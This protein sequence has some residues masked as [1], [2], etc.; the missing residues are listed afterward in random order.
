MDVID[1]AGADAP[2]AFTDETPAR[3]GAREA[4]YQPPAE[5]ERQLAKDHRIH[6]TTSR[7]SL[8]RLAASTAV[9]NSTAQGRAV[10]QRH[11]QKPNA[12]KRSFGA[13]TYVQEQLDEALEWLSDHKSELP[14]ENLD[15]L[16]YQYFE[17]KDYRI[18]PETGMY[19]DDD[20]E[21]MLE[22]AWEDHMIF[23]CVGKQDCYKPLH[24]FAY[25]KDANEYR[26]FGIDLR[27]YAYFM[28]MRGEAYRKHAESRDN[29]LRRDALGA[30]EGVIQARRLYDEGIRINV[31]ELPP[32]ETLK[33]WF[34]FDGNDLRWAKDRSPR[35]RKD[36]KAFVVS[37]DQKLTTF[38][39]QRYS[40]ARI[41]YALEHD[42]DPIGRRIVFLDGDTTDLS[43]SNL[44][45]AGV[46]DS[47]NKESKKKPAYDARLTINGTTHYIGYG[48]PSKEMALAVCE[49]CHETLALMSKGEFA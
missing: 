3:Q 18:D 26:T 45:L 17:E 29:Q 24:K 22:V 36:D 21:P 42:Y 9:M 41:V 34:Y 44:G 19:V 14:S 40:T 8:R 7:Q 37:N 10:E 4:S 35:Q 23:D 2:V 32:M 25:D 5:D 13:S 1:Y 38:D 39:G 15:G 31:S 27:N 46:G 12:L 16:V 28:Q 48:F 11:R 47:V 33:E 20:R 6:P 30:D 49:R 43:V